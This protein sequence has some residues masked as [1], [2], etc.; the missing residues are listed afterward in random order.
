MS[1]RPRENTR[2]L[3]LL[4]FAAGK[5]RVA[6]DP[7][8]NSV[9][10]LTPEVSRTRLEDFTRR[11]FGPNILSSCGIKTDDVAGPFVSYQKL[12]CMD[13]VFD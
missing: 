5:L 6:L 11:D 8:V 3:I 10:D 13:G 1:T 9:L 7:V 12:R 2:C 4:A